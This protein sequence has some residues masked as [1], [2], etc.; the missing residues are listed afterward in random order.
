MTQEGFKLL[1]PE[2]SNVKPLCPLQLELT[3]NTLVLNRHIIKKGRNN[4]TLS[5]I[6]S[7]LYFRLRLVGS[8]LYRS[9]K[10]VYSRVT[11]LRRGW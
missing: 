2:F 5:V 6:R 3:L 8:G 9:I 11:M 7:D 4:N 10:S 1:Y